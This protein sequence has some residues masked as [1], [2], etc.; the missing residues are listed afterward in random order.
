VAPY[1]DRIVPFIGIDPQ[2]GTRALEIM[3]RF[4]K[5]YNARGLK[6]YSATGWY[7]N[8]ARVTAF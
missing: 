7:P 1:R 3:E 4:V 5:K 8:K 2:R 6:V